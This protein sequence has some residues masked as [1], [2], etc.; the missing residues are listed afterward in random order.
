MPVE[1]IMDFPD[2]KHVQVPQIRRIHRYVEVLKIQYFDRI[3]DVPVVKQMEI[4]QIH[5][6]ES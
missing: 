2:V 5:K 1:K 6:V 4:E 3:Q